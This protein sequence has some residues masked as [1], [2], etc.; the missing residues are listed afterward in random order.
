M[1]T[2][3]A[4]VLTEAR[5]PEYT[6]ENR[7]VPCTATNVAIAAVL[8]IGLA[9]ILVTPIGVVA[10]LA[11]LVVIYLRGYLVPGTPELTKR[12]FPP[13]L[14]ALFGKEP[15]ARNVFDV[16]ERSATTE[17]S[18][19]NRTAEAMANGSMATA[20]RTASEAASQDRPAAV[21]AT[22]TAGTETTRSEPIEGG[23]A[24]GTG[25]AA[26][27]LATG[28]TD[29]DAEA[30]GPLF[31]AG[32][33]TRDESGEVV[34]EPSFREAWRER[35]E[36]VRERD[37]EPADVTKLFDAGE[38]RRTGERSFVLDGSASVRWDSA[39]ALVADVAAASLLRERL[40]SWAGFGK[41]DR[42]ATLTGLRLFA[43]RCPSCDGPITTEQDRVD[44]CC[45]KPHR[46]VSA[47]CES[48][49]ALLADAALI[50]TGES[51]PI[52]VRLLR[53]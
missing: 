49:G 5:Q 2:R 52:R 31:A 29:A 45:Q 19:A 3:I 34:L 32:V 41:D 27:S 14:L 40:D 22:A 38:A 9:F 35:I 26:E 4:D 20:N 39:A 16:S 50:D 48:C 18:N 37:V 21:A 47:T 12:Y 7:C 46:V 1:S 6:G 30:D 15:V 44:P 10:F 51:E 24:D 43:T 11:S 33:V 36:S 8:A 13:W 53:P 42:T 28:S 23:T 17:N 25:T